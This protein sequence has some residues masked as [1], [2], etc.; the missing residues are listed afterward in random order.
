MG[1]CCSKEDKKTGAHEPL[2]DKAES[3]RRVGANV[4][5]R[6]RAGQDKMQE[7][8]GRFS[9]TIAWVDRGLAVVGFVPGLQGTCKELRGMLNRVAGAGDAAQDVVDITEKALEAMEDLRLLERTAEAAGGDVKA[10]LETN[11]AAV[12]KVLADITAA[13]DAIGTQGFLKACMAAA[14]S[15]KA[16]A[17]LAT[18]LEQSLDR[19]H[20]TLSLAS[21]TMALEGRFKA[22]ALATQQLQGQL[23]KDGGDDLD[24]GD[25]AAAAQAVLAN[26]QAVGAVAAAAGLSEDAFKKEMKQ[27][28]YQGEQV[29]A[30]LAAQSAALAQ[31]SGQVAAVDH[32]VDELEAQNAE[33]QAQIELLRA[34][35]SADLDEMKQ[36]MRQMLLQGATVDTTN[37]NAVAARTRLVEGALLAGEG[38]DD[39]AAAKIAEGARLHASA[40]SA[41]A[42]GVM[43]RKQKKWVEA[44]AAFLC[45]IALDEDMD[46]AWF[47]LGYVR[48]AGRLN[49]VAGAVTAYRKV[50]ELKSDHAGAHNNLGKLLKKGGDLVGAQASYE[51]AVKAKPEHANAHY[52][53]GL[54]LQ[55][56][57]DLAA[58]QASYERAIEVKP[59]DADAHG[60][61]GNLLLQKGDLDGAQ[62][63]YGRALKAKSD[64]AAG[65]HNNLGKLQEQKGDLAGAQV[66]YERALEL[67]PELASAHFNLGILLARKGRALEAEASY[68]RALEAKPDHARAL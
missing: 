8:L 44:E 66:S 6:A 62:E 4:M 5:D 65:T 26:P 60:N 49:D 32:K 15:A 9:T 21:F 24:E 14:K 3:A 35:M 1:I 52:N 17:R 45:A 68:R 46:G 34:Q 31:I 43:L 40:E 20:K 28:G 54:L 27:L 56:K 53:L 36:M 67:E 19:I 23:E 47:G 33:L 25:R 57:G 11:M 48:S 63:S 51:R 22:E 61:L 50:I 41:V 38:R 39:E 13:V 64:H 55:G 2:M 42:Q 10:E 7:M 18:K 16:L 12:R 30:G 37:A 29:L 59:D 58:A